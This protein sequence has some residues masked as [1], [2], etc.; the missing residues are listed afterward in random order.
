MPFPPAKYL[1]A[2]ALL[3]LC[4]AA[5]AAPLHYQ[6]NTVMRY[7]PGPD[8]KGGVPPAE[9]EADLQIDA[10]QKTWSSGRFSGALEGSGNVLTLKQWGLREG[11]DA[12]FDRSSGAFEYR[13]RSG[14]L[15][16]HQT[17]SCKPLP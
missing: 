14:C 13:F 8:C 9:D 1:V 7:E 4:G 15:A 2:L 6:C 12:T 3:P 10:E 5:L 11:R 16:Q 17:G